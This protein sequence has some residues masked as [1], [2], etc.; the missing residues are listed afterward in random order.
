VYEYERFNRFLKRKYRGCVFF[1][2]DVWFG[3][4]WFNNAYRNKHLHA[5]KGGEEKVKNNEIRYNIS[6]ITGGLINRNTPRN[7]KMDILEN[8]INF[9]RYNFLGFD[10]NGS[11]VRLMPKFHNVRDKSGKFAVKRSR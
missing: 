3:V 2:C 7:V 1:P 5:P 9:D 10:A 4:L 8:T 11:I 6:E